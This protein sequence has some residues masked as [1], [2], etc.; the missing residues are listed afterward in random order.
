MKFKPH[1]ALKKRV[2]VTKTGKVKH[3]PANSKHL[4]S[5]KSAKRLRRLAKD[6]F[7]ATVDVRPLEDMLG[8]RLRGRDQARAAIKRNP[9][10]A[11]RKAAQAAKEAELVK[12]GVGI[13]G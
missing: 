5:H 13:R 9:S 4:K 2:R 11:E 3:K 7:V 1:K 8:R 10:P 12:A 6:T